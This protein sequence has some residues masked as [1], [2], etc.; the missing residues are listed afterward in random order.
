[1]RKSQFSSLTDPKYHG[2]GR[3]LDKLETYFEIKK[4][5]LAKKKKN[6]NN[7]MHGFKSAILSELKNY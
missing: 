2:F 6:N 5:V 3:P 7:S 4:G 1:M